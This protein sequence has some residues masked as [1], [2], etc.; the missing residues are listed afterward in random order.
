MATMNVTAIVTN[1]PC[2]VALPIMLEKTRGMGTARSTPIAHPMPASKPPRR[3]TRRNT[4]FTQ[5]LRNLRRMVV[6][7]PQGDRG[8]AFLKPLGIGNAVNLHSGDALQAVQ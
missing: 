4:S 7:H 1:G 2:S 5:E 3:S 6:A 8:A